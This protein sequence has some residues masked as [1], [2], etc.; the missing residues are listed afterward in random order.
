MYSEDL[1]F[2]EDLGESTGICFLV[3]IEMC[4]R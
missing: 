3:G 4:R 1:G 2:E